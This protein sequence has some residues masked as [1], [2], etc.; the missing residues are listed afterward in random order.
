MSGEERPLVWL[1]GEV[2]TP[3]FSR[4]ARLAAGVLLR[5][6]QRGEALGMPH[7]RPMPSIG[8]RCH[9]LRIRDRESNWRIV[10]RLDSDAVVLLAVF[11][12]KSQRT[13]ARVINAC[14]VRLRNYD[15]E[16]NQE[17]AP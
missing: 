4:E 1:Q 15:D 17:N 16:G 9:E 7:S 13:P 10:Y 11:K 2:R 6:V 8:K 14:K 12:K 3:P 5:R